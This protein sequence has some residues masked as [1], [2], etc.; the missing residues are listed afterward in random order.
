MRTWKK[1]ALVVAMIL[2]GVVVAT[3]GKSVEWL[4]AVAVLLT[5]FHCQ[6]G[7][8]LSEAEDAREKLWRTDRFRLAELDAALAPPLQPADHTPHL[9]HVE[10][11]RWLTRYFLAKEV[12]WLTYFVWLGAWSALVGVG[13]FLVYPIWRRLHV[14]RRLA[15]MS[16]L[17]P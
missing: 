15:Q 17:P 8:R 16:D 14:K 4:G 10:C 1:E 7:F 6:V 5:F 11:H 9:A 13:V 3:G 12:V 2:A